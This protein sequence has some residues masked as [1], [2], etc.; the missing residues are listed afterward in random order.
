MFKNLLFLFA[1]LF[2]FS[3]ILLAQKYQF[4]KATYEIIEDS[5]LVEKGKTIWQIEP[6]VYEITI[7]KRMY[8]PRHNKWMKN[9]KS[10]RSCACRKCEGLNNC[11]SCLI[12]QLVAIPAKYKH[13]KTKTLKTPA[14]FEAV[15]EPD[16]YQKNKKI[17]KLS[18]AKLRKL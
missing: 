9:G 8:I 2:F 11:D 16:I 12:W 14:H 17:V 5:I 3:N 4:Q 13:Y 10:G 7:E 15:K 18:P 1:T 6:P